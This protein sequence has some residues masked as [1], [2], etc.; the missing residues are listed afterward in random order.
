MVPFSPRFVWRENSEG[1]AKLSSFPQPCEGGQ[2]S[3]LE[4]DLGNDIG[5][6]NSAL[7][8]CDRTK[9]VTLA[10]DAFSLK[11]LIPTRQNI[12]YFYRSI[13]T[14]LSLWVK[15]GKNM[16]K[17][18]NR[19]NKRH[20]KEWNITPPSND[21]AGHWRYGEDKYQII[22][23]QRG[24]L[25][26]QFTA[27]YKTQPEKWQFL[28]WTNYCNIFSG[29]RTFQRGKQ[30]KLGGECFETQIWRGNKLSW[31]VI[32]L[33]RRGSISAGSLLGV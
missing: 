28:T 8:P 10:V 24:S 22:N 21:P 16:I 17:E 30:P 26:Y 4:R 18:R 7:L 25:F 5:R 11:L 6:I 9:R 12:E 27:K 14:P 20:L 29:D 1:K 15:F 33:P 13:W 3:G 2:Y 23:F 31:R 19:Q 32:M